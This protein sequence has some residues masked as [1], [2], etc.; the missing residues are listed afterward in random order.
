ME[1]RIITV[2]RSL[3]IVWLLVAG[4]AGGLLGSI[5]TAKGGWFG[6]VV[7]AGPVFQVTRSEPLVNVS[8]LAEGF[9]PVVKKALP[10]VVNI[11]TTKIVRTRPAGPF[12]FFDDPFFR[13]FF[14]FGWD[15]VPRERRETS[16]GSGVIVSSDGYILTNDHV[17]SGATEII[18]SLADKRE[19]K[20]K[21]VGSDPKTDIAVL[22][23]E[24]KNLPTLPLGDS[25]KVE[26]GDI[27]LAMGNPFGIGQ[28]VTM[29]IVS[30]T[31]RGGLGIETYEDFIQTDAA[32]N[33]GNSGGPLVNMRG[34]VIGI[35]TAIISRSGGYQGIGFA[36]P[37]NMA[38]EVMEQ[39]IKKG[40]V[41]RGWLGVTIQPVTSQVAQALGLKEAKGA[42]VADVQKDS[43]ADKAGLKTG[44]IIQAV[45]NKEIEDSRDLQLT[46]ARMA[47]GTTVTL[48][49]LRD[50]KP[51]TVTA[52]LGEYPEE[53]REVAFAPGEE[54]EAL[55]LDVQDL[56]P[57]I[58]RQLGLPPN[59]FGVV[60]TAVA[61]GS[62]AEDAG[63]RRGDVI[64]EVNRQPVQNERA[65]WQAVRRA[66]KRPLLLLV[67]RGGSTFFAV[68]EPR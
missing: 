60:V 25:S 66:G 61:P 16:L 51:I 37:I 57:Q 26:V 50:G 44:D 10:A 17:I 38:R 18:V 30:A 1:N 22:K 54:R 9:R 6:K 28:T 33:P 15:F 20:A 2:K 13:D 11:S 41:V 19:L 24:E 35:N 65:F 62:A 58:A 49:V 52:T 27:V 4:L 39:I 47:P 45:N 53:K 55:G 7:H 56:T 14:G 32:I 36:V 40:R 21:V 34:E 64:Q 46:I 67:N 43:P 59:T 8:A 23:V 63:L 31:G 48:K 3:A 5:A 68:I 12:P 42:L 29:G